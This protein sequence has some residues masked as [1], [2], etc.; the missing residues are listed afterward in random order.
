MPPTAILLPVFAHVAL[1]FYVLFLVGRARYVAGSTGAVKL[2]DIAL[3]DKGWPDEA[4]KKANNYRNQFE[5]PVLFYALVA[6]LLITSKADMAEVVLAWLFV[7]SRFV[8]AA[9]HLGSNKVR[10]RGLAFM[11]GVAILAVMWIWFGLRL[12]FLG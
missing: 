2:Q 11:V 9:I 12:Y 1:V 7:A 4:R 5:L 10:R 3:D 6:F 8:H